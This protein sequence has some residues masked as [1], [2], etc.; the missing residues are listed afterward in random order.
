[1]SVSDQYQGLVIGSGQG[2]TPLCRALGN[3]VSIIAC[4]VDYSENIKLTDQL[5]EFEFF[6]NAR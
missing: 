1:M 2:G 6:P 4:P 5:G 3:T